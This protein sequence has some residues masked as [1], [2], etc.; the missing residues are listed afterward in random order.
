MGC[1]AEVFV[2][3]GDPHEVG[4]DDE[5]L[6]G[7]GLEGA[8]EQRYDQ[9][10]SALHV[11]F[12]GVLEGE[13][14]LEDAV[15]DGLD[16]FALP[17]L[18]VILLPLERLDEQSRTRVKKRRPALET[19]CQRTK[20]L[21]C[22]DQPETV[23]A[24]RG[25]HEVVLDREG[26]VALRVG[27]GEAVDYGRRERG[28]PLKEDLPESHKG[29]QLVH[30]GAGDVYV[31][32][33]QLGYDRP[34]TPHL[35]Q[36]GQV[37]EGV[38]EQSND[39]SHHES[40]TPDVSHLIEEGRPSSLHVSLL[41]G[42]LKLRRKHVHHRFKLPDAGQKAQPVPPLAHEALLQRFNVLQRHLRRAPLGRKGACL[43]T[44]RSRH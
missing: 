44:T 18:D 40:R 3:R 32:V 35:E 7:T 39:G 13:E 24:D 34:L 43:P 41:S 1:E 28:D 36:A 15:E 22:E 5:D 29:H 20:R 6:S 33:P 26:V 42:G 16:Q 4:V 8:A 14:R 21:L 38:V 17:A 27:E 19:L 10:Q 23:P 37:H 30:L 31:L 11:S 2:A 9:K 25:E 12:G